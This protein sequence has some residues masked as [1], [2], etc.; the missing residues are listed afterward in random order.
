VAERLAASEEGLGSM[1]LIQCRD[2]DKENS[3]TP[4]FGGTSVRLI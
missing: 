3:H 2:I 1:E 4:G